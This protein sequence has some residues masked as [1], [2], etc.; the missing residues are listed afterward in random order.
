MYGTMLRHPS[1]SSLPVI[2]EYGDEED[3]HQLDMEN[4]MAASEE[5]D[6][7]TIRR[8][9]FNLCVV[10]SDTKPETDSSS[11][12]RGRFAVTPM[13]SVNSVESSISDSSNAT[14]QQKQSSRG[15]GSPHVDSIVSQSSKYRQLLANGQLDQSSM[16]GVARLLEQ[17]ELALLNQPR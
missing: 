7:G 4:S 12:R 2:V 6:T 14:I 10:S 5:S 3:Q 16:E 8:G 1:A 9:R 13:S 11:E 15:G 17:M